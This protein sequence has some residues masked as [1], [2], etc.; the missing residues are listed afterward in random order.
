MLPGNVKLSV[1]GVFEFSGRNSFGINAEVPDQTRAPV[2]GF[3]NSNIAFHSSYVGEIPIFFQFRVIENV[4][5]VLI[6]ELILPPSI[7]NLY[8]LALEAAL[9]LSSAH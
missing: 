4:L 2:E 5:P 1:T 8:P 3:L 9:K 6:V 7:I